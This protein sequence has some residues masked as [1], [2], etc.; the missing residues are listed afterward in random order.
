VAACVAQAGF[1]I[2]PERLAPEFER[3]SPAAGFGR[4]FSFHS[5]QRVG[6]GLLKAAVL[7]AV[8]IVVIRGRWGTVVGLDRGTIEEALASGWELCLRLALYLAGTLVVFGALDYAVQWRRLELALRM[9]KQELKDEVRREEGDPLI[10][11][12]I[13]QLQRQRAQLRL[14]KVVPR[15]TV[16]ITNPTHYAV[17]LRYNRATDRAPVVLAKGAGVMAR[18]IAEI[19]RRHAVPVVERPVVAR[20]IYASVKEG[21]EIPPTLFRAV[22]EV[23]A[24]VFRLRGAA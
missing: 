1:H 21:Q 18:Y 20:A 17:A 22:A 15:A 23:I 12:R 11:A 10:R 13:R 16:V 2:L 8:A 7:V 24:F 6:L 9:T 14:Q 5:A 19:A 4:V 3:I